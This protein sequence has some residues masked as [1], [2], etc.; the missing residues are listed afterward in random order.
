[1][2]KKVLAVKVTGKL[3]FIISI[4]LVT[5]DSFTERKMSNLKTNLKNKK[6]H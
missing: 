5:R 1:M 6:S 2:R 4:R 3:A